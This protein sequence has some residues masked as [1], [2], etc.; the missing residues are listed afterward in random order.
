MVGVRK[1]PYG[2]RSVC[3]RDPL[4]NRESAKLRKPTICWWKRKTPGNCLTAPGVNW[5]EQRFPI[6]ETLAPRGVQHSHHGFVEFGAFSRV[7]RGVFAFCP[8]NVLPAITETPSKRQASVRD[9][10]RLAWYYQ[11]LLDS[12][13]FKT[14][15]DLARFLGV[16]RA[17]VTQVLKRLNAHH[18]NLPIPVSA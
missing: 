11:S 2:F 18:L 15:A 16:S 10:L 5:F 7:S 12:G 3:G 8:W 4:R 17:R 9:P 13:E 14:R 6:R 1:E